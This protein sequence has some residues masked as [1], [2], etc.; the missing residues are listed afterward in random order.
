MGSN[1]IG[2]R[3]LLQRAAAALDQAP[4]LSSTSSL[5][6]RASSEGDP[7]ASASAVVQTHFDVDRSTH[8]AHLWLL[9]GYDY[10]SQVS[11]IYY[12]GETQYIQAAGVWRKSALPYEVA[13]RVFA[14]GSAVALA[15][16]GALGELQVSSATT[17]VPG[18]VTLRARISSEAIARTIAAA[19]AAAEAAA[20]AGGAAVPEPPPLADADLEIDIASDVPMIRALRV[21][22]A[23]PH[24][25][26]DQRLHSY[27][28]LSAEM[29]ILSPS[30]QVII[31][32]TAR[33]A[34]SL[35]TED[36]A[37][38][39]GGVSAACLCTGCAACA[40]CL[41]C[42]VC[43]SCVACIFPPL[44]APV[45]ATA[46]GTAIATAIST[47]VGASVGVATAIQQGG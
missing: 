15:D 36:L 2:A 7:A 13:D 23:G 9:E 33:A 40:A 5:V 31:P 22:S 35:G 46:A 47:A 25:S 8:R 32:P 45:T 17:A 21:T 1:E 10:T 29:R 26:G 18:T 3:Q 37:L 27:Q 16:L 34:A 39:E 30:F 4:K 43:I 20:A 42:L 11:E 14:R 38:A 19:A 44:L 24:S 41:A 28:S 12:D 6:I